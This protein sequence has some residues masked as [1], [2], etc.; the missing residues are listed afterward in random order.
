MPK[1]STPKPIKGTA[2]NEMKSKTAQSVLVGVFCMRCERRHRDYLSTFVG[3]THVGCP[4]CGGSINL[5]GPKNAL[6]IRELARACANVDAVVH[7][8]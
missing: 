4:H 8:S 1:P 3:P 6:L 7:Q 2:G 5:D